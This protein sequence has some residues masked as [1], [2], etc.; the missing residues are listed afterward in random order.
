[1]P[2]INKGVHAKTIP[3]TLGH[4]DIRMTMN[5]YGHALQAADQAAADKFDL[6]IRKKSNVK[7]AKELSPAS[8]FYL[9]C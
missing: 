8:L 4:A 3:V 1:M 6:K 5:I 2:L 7:D 9:Q